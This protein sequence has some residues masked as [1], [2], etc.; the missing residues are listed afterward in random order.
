MGDS[1]D[2]ISHSFA[3]RCRAATGLLPL[4]RPNGC[5]INKWVFMQRNFVRLCLAIFA[6]GC[7]QG[8]Q[9][10]TNEA[11]LVNEAEVQAGNTDDS[12]TI[13]GEVVDQ[14]GLLVEAFEAAETWSSNGVYWNEAGQVPTDEDG[15]RAI[16]T[17]EGVLAVRPAN[18][19]APVS[20]GVFRLK[21]QGS[22]SSRPN[23]VVF[24]VNA[25]HTLGGLAMVERSVSKR[26]IRI[27]LKPLVRVTAEIYC[28]ERGK[29]PEWCQAVVYPVGGD[30]MYFTKCGTYQGR[31]SFLLPA[32]EY[33]IKA[34][35]DDLLPRRIRIRVPNGVETFD[36]GV[37]AIELPK[38]ADDNAVDITSFYGKA[39]PTLEITDASG[40]PKDVKLE[41]YRG[42]WILL[43]FWAVWCG[44][45][46]G[47]SLPRLREFYEQHASARERFEILTICDTSSDNVK[48]MEEFESHSANLVR[49]V[50]G[51]KKLPFPVL[52]DGEGRT[53][54][55]FGIVR[56]PTLLLVDPDGNLVKDGDLKMLAN[57]LEGSN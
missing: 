41:D 57:L 34:D 20:K 6:L 38:D 50:W 8:R 29:T 37:I 45:C 56:R 1:T 47:D 26:P 13:T 40:V 25:D 30:Y 24:A 51:G 4:R 9:P 33:E 19:A 23:S 36:A 28:P 10:V 44:P 49:N 39:P 52:V 42:K 14:N 21:I 16:W 17:Q 15:Q 54:K 55:S 35:S 18:L 53:A 5:I 2:A 22:P 31:V 46:V 3:S 32:G 48:T 27:E 11:T 43:E 12:W 7:N